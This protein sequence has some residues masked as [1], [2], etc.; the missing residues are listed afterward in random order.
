MNGAGAS[1]L[2]TRRIMRVT[3]GRQMGAVPFLREV[4]GIFEQLP[5]AGDQGPE[6]ECR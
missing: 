1:M 3:V 6:Y 2:G 5:P 4:Q